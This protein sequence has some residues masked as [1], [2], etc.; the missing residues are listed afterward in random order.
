MVDMDKSRLESVIRWAKF[1]RENPVEWK[2]SHRKFIDSQF[3]IH[4][5]FVQKMLKKE[6][7]KKKLRKL[8]GLNNKEQYPRFY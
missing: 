8:Y 7:G 3:E 4:K 5:R 6:D 2:N 1:V